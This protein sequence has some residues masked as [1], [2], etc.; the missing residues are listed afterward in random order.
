MQPRCYLLSCL[1]LKNDRSHRLDIRIKTSQAAKHF[2]ASQNPHMLDS[3]LF[4]RL[5]TESANCLAGVGRLHSPSHMVTAYR[6]IGKL[7]S[8]F[9]VRAVLAYFCSAFKA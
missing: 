9:L 4:A 3:K 2:L 1:G 8:R 7:L 5:M 6:R